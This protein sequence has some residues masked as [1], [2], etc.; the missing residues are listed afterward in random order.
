MLASE[1]GKLLNNC[2]WVG[3][4]FAGG[5]SEVR[6]LTART[7]AVNDLH[8]AIINLACVLADLKLGPKLIRILRRVPFHPVALDKCQ[9]RAQVI[10]QHDLLEWARDYF[11]CAWMG[12]NGIAGTGG[13]YTNGIA[14]RWEAGGGVAKY[15]VMAG[16]APVKC[17]ADAPYYEQHEVD[18]FT[19]VSTYL[20]HQTTVGQRTNLCPLLFLRA[21]RTRLLI[22]PGLLVQFLFRHLDQL[23]RQVVKRLA[24]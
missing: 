9:H 6:H 22:P 18:P 24:C 13:E 23:A 3:V 20:T 4:C 11:V 14:M 2:N 19:L 21:L 16:K 5:M 10:I 12:R 7:I 17:K 8:G 1:V 15:D